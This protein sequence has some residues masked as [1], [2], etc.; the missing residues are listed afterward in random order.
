MKKL[1][2]HVYPVCLPVQCPRAV[3]VLPRPFHARAGCSRC[4]SPFFLL[5]LLSSRFTLQVSSHWLIYPEPSVVG[6]TH[7]SLTCISPPNRHRKIPLFE[8]TGC[9][10]GLLDLERGWPVQGSKPPLFAG[11]AAQAALGLP[12]H[13]LSPGSSLESVSLA[14]LLRCPI[15]I[16]SHLSSVLVCRRGLFFSPKSPNPLTTFVTDS[17]N[18][19]ILQTPRPLPYLLS[20]S[21]LLDNPETRTHRQLH[22]TW[23]LPSPGVDPNC[24]PLFLRTRPRGWSPLSS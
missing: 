20:S 4:S 10:R 11:Q 12:F 1:S 18:C 14:F 9:S 15:P 21:L 13:T 7:D 2:A 6:L 19:G 16:S 8:T 17:A 5:P 23:I 24:P 22:S 3:S